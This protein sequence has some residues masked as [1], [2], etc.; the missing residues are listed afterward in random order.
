MSTGD[1]DRL[2]EFVAK[3]VNLDQT[4]KTYHLPTWKSKDD[5]ARIRAL[6]EISLK[7]GR[8]PDIATLAV[9]IIRDAGVQPRSYKAQAAALLSWV[10]SQIYYINEPGERLQD[11]VYTLKVRYG[12][13]DDMA[14]LLASL[15]EACRLPWR[16]VLSGRTPKNKLV[17]WVE[18]TP[19][20]RAKWSHIYIVVGYPPYTPKK[21]F[22]AEPT[23]KRVPL[24]WDVVG[25][26]KSN[27]GKVA[28]P[29]LGS[30]TGEASD[31]RAPLM[32]RKRTEKKP[33]L[34]H[35]KEEIKKSLHPRKVIPAIIVGLVM[36]A[37]SGRVR[38]AVGALIHGENKKK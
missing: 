4:T 19:K 29:E 9:N 11:P 35:A 1:I 2:G 10:Q 31:K 12:D 33:I 5:A 20:K 3:R 34:A 30:L 6:R 28:L 22:Y 24:G 38:A 36:A 23:L 26:A 7:G 13:C 8:D 15:Y 18:G 16:Y 17:R 27:G 37:M 21:W 32:V 25:A 14:I